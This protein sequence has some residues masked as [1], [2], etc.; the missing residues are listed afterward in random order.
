MDRQAQ[1]LSMAYRLSHAAVGQ[2]WD[3]L[4]RVDSELAELL[5]RLARHSEWSPVEQHALQGL[6]DAHREALACC[7]RESVQLDA[8]IADMCAH[9]DAWVAYTLNTD[10]QESQA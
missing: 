9:K 8:R 2:D 1:L 4:A 3:E 7:V 5:P 10:W 6:R